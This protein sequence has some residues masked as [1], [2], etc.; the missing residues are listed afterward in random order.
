MTVSSST[1]F[2]PLQWPS[3]YQ[4]ICTPAA[5]SISVPMT[6][7]ALFP[8]TV[9][10]CHWLHSLTNYPACTLTCETSYLSMIA[11]LSMTS[12]RNQWKLHS[13]RWLCSLAKD[14]V[15]L[16]MA[17]HPKQW[18][19]IPASE[20]S[21]WQMSMHSYQQHAYTT[22]WVQ[23]NNRWINEHTT[24]INNNYDSSV[25][26]NKYLNHIQIKSILYSTIIF[27]NCPSNGHKYTFRF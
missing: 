16:P 27:T 11:P 25:K 8:V 3:P 4:W 2:S 18:N 24:N 1:A 12:H 15:F 7:H 21:A 23:T 13:C 22:T 17:M 6:L 10:S 19:C 20:V 14:I 26:A 9:H 5:D